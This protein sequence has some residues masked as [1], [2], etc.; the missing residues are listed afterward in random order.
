MNN[1]FLDAV[2][3]RRSIYDLG[4][5]VTLS[6]DA[7]V[8]IVQQAVQHA[9]TAFHSQGPRAVVLFDRQHQ[10]LWDIVKE[11]L[12]K[13]VPAEGFAATEEKIDAFARGYGTVLFFDDQPTVQNLQKSFPLYSENFPLWATQAS[14]MAQHTVWVALED[15]GL[16]ASLQHYNPL[17]DDEVRKQWNLPEGWKLM[18]Q[19]PFGSVGSPAGEKDFMPIGE[20][21]RVFK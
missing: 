7:I 10:A 21:V 20:R 5:E 13:V 4:K 6:Q 17:I 15:A 8:G 1:T 9:P 2:K 12:R 19:M 18:S 3:H 14:G 16:G 11:A